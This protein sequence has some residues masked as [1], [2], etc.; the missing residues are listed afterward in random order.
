M[1]RDAKEITM[2]ERNSAYPSLSCF[3]TFIVLIKTQLPPDYCSATAFTVAL[4]MM[5][6]MKV[7]VNHRVVS[8]QPIFSSLY[9]IFIS[10]RLY[11]SLSRQTT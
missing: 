3:D 2:K 6:K 1:T 5:T 7:G 8:L 10:L 11:T 9:V 4:E